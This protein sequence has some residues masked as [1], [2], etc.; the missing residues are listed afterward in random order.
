VTQVKLFDPFTRATG[1]TLA[2]F[3]N[4]WTTVHAEIAKGIPQIRH[5]VQSHRIEG[6]PAPITTALGERTCDGSSETWYDSPTE[7]RTMLSEPGLEQLMLDEENFMDLAIDRYPTITREHPIDAARL[8]SRAHGV[9]LLLFV[10][11]A[12]ATAAEFRAQ[13]PR[14]DDAA[15][16][17][18]VG[19]TRHV[20]CTA[21]DESYSFLHPN[22]DVRAEASQP[23]DGVRELWWPDAEALTRGAGGRPDAWAQLTRP[24]AVDAQRSFAL[25]A[26]ERVIIP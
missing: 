21:L 5:Y 6:M 22:P 14:D 4:H 26:R 20:A 1:T 17:R 10:R 12:V 2:A 9:K 16:G 11:R 24:D 23:Y 18:A 13:W 7:I 15:L 25:F 3:S 8:D 19:A